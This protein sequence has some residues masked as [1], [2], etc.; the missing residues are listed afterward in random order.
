MKDF[1]FYYGGGKTTEI[2]LKEYSLTSI[3]KKVIIIDGDKQDNLKSNIDFN[4]IDGKVRVNIKNEMIQDI[5]KQYRSIDKIFVDNANSLSID[6]IEDLYTLSKLYDIPVDLYGRREANGIRCMELADSIIKLNDFPF[7]RRGNELAYYYGTMNSGK[8]IKLIGNLEYLN[9]DYNTYLMKPRSD[10]EEEYILSRLGLRKKVDYI[11]DPDTKLLALV[12]RLKENN[13]NFIF[14]DE[15]Q[16]LSENQIKC[17]RKIVDDYKIPVLG[18]GL[19]TDFRRNSFPGSRE[20]LKQADS[21]VKI[22]GQCAC[23]GNESE[24]NA[25]KNLDTGEYI[26][27]G[28]QVVIDGVNCG[29]DA[30]CPECYMKYVLKKDKVLVR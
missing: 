3:G 24:F 14:I 16:F 8:T 20:L 21:I 27:D 4:T 30:L 11:I 5:Y 2:L 23:C 13:I 7:L 22:D 29:Y 12:D 15:I 17:L 1:K 18:Y 26:S 6:N 19:K 10:R 25:R 9:K 28:E